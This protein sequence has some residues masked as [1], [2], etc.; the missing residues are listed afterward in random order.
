[1]FGACASSLNIYRDRYL[2]KVNDILKQNKIIIKKFIF[3]L[4]INIKLSSVSV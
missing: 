3:E 4:I 1:M 2:E